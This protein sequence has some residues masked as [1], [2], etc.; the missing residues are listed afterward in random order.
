MG[1]LAQHKFEVIYQHMH[2]QNSKAILDQSAKVVSRRTRL[3]ERLGRSRGLLENLAQI[4]SPASEVSLVFRP[5]ASLE[6]HFFFQMHPIAKAITQGLDQI[7]NVCDEILLHNPTLTERTSR[8]W[9]NSRIG[10][11][12]CSNSLATWLLSLITWTTSKLLQ[13]WPISK[14]ICKISSR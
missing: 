5:S 6:L 11:T 7:Y 14:Q 1:F 13:P 2:M 8:S 10:M 12:N 9:S 4:L 3:L